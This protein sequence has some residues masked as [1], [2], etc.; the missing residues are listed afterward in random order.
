MIAMAV[1]QLARLASAIMSARDIL[2]C[3]DNGCQI[4]LAGFDFI[5]QNWCY[6]AMKH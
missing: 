1:F 2:M 6:P 3:V 4:Y 5:L